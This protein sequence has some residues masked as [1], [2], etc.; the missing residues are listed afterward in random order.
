M[1]EGS[2]WYYVVTGILGYGSC[3]G[4]LVVG[5]YWRWRSAKKRGRKP[6]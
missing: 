6:W 2:F 1:E 5:Y 3:I 4:I